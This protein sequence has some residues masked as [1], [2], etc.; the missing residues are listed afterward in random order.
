MIPDS[1][2]QLLYVLPLSWIK[3]FVEHRSLR[4]CAVVMLQHAV[5]NEVCSVITLIISSRNYVCYIVD[6]VSGQHL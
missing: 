3:A 2:W 6:I 4:D 1:I 5:L